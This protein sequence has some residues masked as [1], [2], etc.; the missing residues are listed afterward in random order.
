[1]NGS[2]FLLTVATLE[3]GDTQVQDAQLVSAQW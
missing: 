3:S 1:M 2:A